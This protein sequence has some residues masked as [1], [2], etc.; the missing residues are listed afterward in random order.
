MKRISTLVLT[1]C[2]IFGGGAQAAA[3]EV[4]PSGVMDFVFVYSSGPL[5][6]QGVQ[7]DIAFDRFAARQRSRIQVDFIANENLRGVMLLRF[8]TWGHSGLDR[9]LFFRR[10]KRRRWQIRQNRLSGL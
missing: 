5:W 9:N 7:D 4:V 8:G 6:D 10:Q 2:L 3:L 1:L